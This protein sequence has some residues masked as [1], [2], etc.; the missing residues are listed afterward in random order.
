MDD[1]DVSEALKAQADYCSRE[2]L[3]HFAP[4]DGICWKCNNQIYE[5]IPISRA[6]NSLVTG[7]PW[8]YRSYCD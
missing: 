6:A 2:K 8:C 3:P 7:C 5:K 1:I 4:D